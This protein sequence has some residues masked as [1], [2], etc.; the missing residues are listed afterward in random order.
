MI[1]LTDKGAEKVQEF[2][3][4]QAAV[5]ETAGLR[6]GVRGGGCSGFQYALAFDEEHDG[7]TVFEDQGIRL[8]VDRASLPYVEGSVIDFVDGL[9][10]AGFKVENPNVIAA[11]GCGS[12]FRVADLAGPPGDATLA[13]ASPMVGAVRRSKI[14]AG[15]TATTLAVVVLVAGCGGSSKPASTNAS[16]TFTGT[17]APGGSKPHIITVTLPDLKPLTPAEIRRAALLTA[18]EPG[19]RA[20]VRAS[21]TVP[22]LGNSPITATGSGYFD[23][24]SGTGTVNIVLTLPGLLGLAGPLPSQVVAVGDEIYFKIPSDLTSIAR[25]VSPWQQASLSELDLSTLDPSVILGQVAR[26]ATR[27]VPDQHAKVTINAKTGLIRTIVLTYY[28]PGPR[29]RVVIHI[30]LTGFGQELVSTAP[31]SDEVGQLFSLLKTLGF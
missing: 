22:Q 17:I 18:A 5:A 12:S 11:C 16:S 1:T 7:D 24:K 31:P 4:G 2:L 25:S 21:I 9:Q 3:A 27:K 10:G 8:L 23:S 15:V 14:R 13:V 20:R 6:V 29:V 26:D 28:E 30:T 19:Y